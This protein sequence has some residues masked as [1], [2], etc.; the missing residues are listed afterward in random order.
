M[1][2]LRFISPNLTRAIRCETAK[3]WLPVDLYVGGAEHAVMHLLYA[4]FWT[5]SC[6]MPGLV[7]FIEPFSQLRNQGNDAGGRWQQ[8]SKSKNNVF[9]PDE[10]VENNG[11]DALRA[12]ILFL[13]HLNLN[14]RGQMRYAWHARFVNRVYDL[15]SDES[16][17]WQR[18]AEGKEAEDLYRIM[19]PHDQGGQQRTRQFQ[20]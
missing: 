20:L 14:C 2:F 7:N 16:G 15:I 5:R 17:Q 4:R 6:M 3:F 18:Q 10:M 13:A 12:F 9:T 19:A 8:E 11:A 1:V